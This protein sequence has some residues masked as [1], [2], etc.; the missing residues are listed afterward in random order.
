MIQEFIAE[1]EA[2]LGFI[3]DE[4]LAKYWVEFFGDNPTEEQLDELRGELG[5]KSMLR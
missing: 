1:I 3:F 5:I 2:G 4:D